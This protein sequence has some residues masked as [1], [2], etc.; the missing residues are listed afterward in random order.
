MDKQKKELILLTVGL[1]AIGLAVYFTF[2]PKAPAAAPENAAPT[3]SKAAAPAQPPGQETQKAEAGREERQAG[4]AAEKQAPKQVS[5]VATDEPLSKPGRDPFQGPDFASASPAAAGGAAASMRPAGASGS[6]QRIPPLPVVP[7][8]SLIASAIAGGA[9]PPLGFAAA[10]QEKL[11]VTGII[12]GDP[13]VAILRKGER[14]FI[15]REGDPVGSQYTVTKI[16]ARRV[17]LSAGE[18]DQVILYL[19]GR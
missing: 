2:R 6:A 9:Q 13:N 12:Q 16:S 11:R 7:P 8:L 19:S 4:T 10:P 14:R 18:H 17:V 1:V 15:V 5:A 3:A